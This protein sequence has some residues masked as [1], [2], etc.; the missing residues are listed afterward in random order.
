MP[1]IEIPAL[2]MRGG[3]S[4][5]VFLREQDLPSDA[6]ARD[7]MLLRM[8][9]SPDRFGTQMDGMGGGTSST[10]KVMIVTGD[11]DAQVN[12]SFGQVAIDRGLID[13]S[14][15][16]GNLAAAVGAFALWR[17]LVR[18]Q[19]GRSARLLLVN[20]NNGSR[21]EAEIPVL[22]GRPVE[23]GEYELDGVAFPGAEIRLAF[24]CDENNDAAPVFAKNSPLAMLEIP[25]LG[26]LEATLVMAGNPTVIVDAASLG[27]R[28]DETQR[29]VNEDVALLERLE[30][31]RAHAAVEMGIASTP[32]EAS[33]ER[34]HAPKIAWVARSDGEMGA[35]QRTDLYARTL[36][37]GKLHHAMTGTGAVAIAM[38]GAVPGTVVEQVLGG[39][40][41]EVRIRHASGAMS[42]GAE[43][44]C[45]SG[46][47]T[48][49][50]ALLSRSARRLMDGVLI[51]P[52]CD[53]AGGAA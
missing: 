52:A 23:E 46:Q 34:L 29:Q 41:T 37:M 27:L 44:A 43:A 28:G 17:G 7:R 39:P 40:R 36:S 15:S 31:V 32:E 47:W 26:K 5:G 1:T 45:R 3:T 2:Y 16:C 25:A 21:I 11:G 42:V 19:E 14:G 51:V 50:R 35:N 20:R 13:W 9:G 24:L 22:N 4:K 48:V 53:D 12:Y 30:R 38:A 49:S 18:A 6:A 33:R 8:M 10:S